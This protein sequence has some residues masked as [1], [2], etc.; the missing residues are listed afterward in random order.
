MKVEIVE[1]MVKEVGANPRQIAAVEK[2]LKEGCTIPFIARYRKEAH[3]NLDEVAIGKIKDRMEYYEELE[4]R[5]ET[6]LKSIEEQ[7]KL[8]D[9]LARAINDCYVKSKLED[10]YQPYKPKRKTR[11]TIAK[12]KGFEPLADAIWNGTWKGEGLGEGEAATDEDLQ[13]ARDILAERI[14]DIAD[15][16]GCVRN[17]FATQS[18]VKS[19]VASPKPTEPTKFEQYYDFSESISTIRSM[20]GSFSSSR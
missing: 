15:V 7:G 12:E 4:A 9:E 6:V 19:E 16:R 5:K 17:A 13:F 18:V 2:L 11:A 3:G 20:T 8:T 1:R 14:A 10:L